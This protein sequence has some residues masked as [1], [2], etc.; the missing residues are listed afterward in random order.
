MTARR[1]SPQEKKRLSYLKDRRNKYG[2]NEKSSRKSIRHHKRA[3]NSANR[4]RMQLTL[5]RL[6]NSPV[7]D[8]DPVEQAASRRRPKSW[9]KVPDVPLGEVVVG[10]LERRVRTETEDGRRARVRIAKVRRRLGE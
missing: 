7:A 5:A 2:E 10:G 8:T 3:T 1:R 4:R 6:T 9:K